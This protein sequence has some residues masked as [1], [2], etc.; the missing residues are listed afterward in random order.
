MK[1]RIHRAKPVP[2]VPTASMADIAFLLIIFFM[3][4]TSFSPER[5][6]V[7]MPSSVTREQ[8]RENPA[9]VAITADGTVAFSD[10]E[11]A[12]EP[13]LSMDELQTRT[14][15]LLQDFPGTEFVIK[16]DRSVQYRFID[17]V[18]EALRNGG[19]QDIGLLTT[20]EVSGGIAAPDEESP[21]SPSPTQEEDGNG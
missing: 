4:T 20:Q 15:A 10:G 9:I 1:R 16:A 17:G 2:V 13:V 18:L 19:A 8:V 7:T 14:E 5:T 11:S 6:Q 3:L 12:S 21:E